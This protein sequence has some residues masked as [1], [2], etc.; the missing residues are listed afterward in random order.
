M[1]RPLLVASTWTE[2]QEGRN[3]SAI[4]TEKSGWFLSAC[5]IVIQ[6]TR[7]IEWEEREEWWIICEITIPYIIILVPRAL[8]YKFN[9][10]A[11]GQ[12]S[13]KVFLDDLNHETTKSFSWDGLWFPL[14]WCPCLVMETDAKVISHPTEISVELPYFIDLVWT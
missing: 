5:C 11:F 8:L 12:N 6:M 10:N 14:P 2:D 4:I 7:L 9:R 3:G 13:N 1:C